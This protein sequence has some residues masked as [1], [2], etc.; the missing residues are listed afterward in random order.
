[1]NFVLFELSL[2]MNDCRTYFSSKPKGLAVTVTLSFLCYCFSICLSWRAFKFLSF[3]KVG[4]KLRLLVSL[5]QSESLVPAFDRLVKCPRLPRSL[6][7][8]I[9]GFITGRG[10]FICYLWAVGYEFGIET[11]IGCIYT[12]ECGLVVCFVVLGLKTSIMSVFW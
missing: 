1:M 2:S 4:L 5:L 7:P 11:R 3:T 8:E 9:S 10:F 12:G 6:L